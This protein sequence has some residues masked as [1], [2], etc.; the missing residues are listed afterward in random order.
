MSIDYR[1]EYNEYRERLW[2]RKKE[3][4]AQLSDVDLKQQDI[5]H[6]LEN[7]KCDAVTMVR[8]AK[9]LKT[10]RTERRLI[11]NEYVE[12]EPV[13]NRLTNAIKAKEKK[14]T[15]TY[16]TDIIV[17]CIGITLSN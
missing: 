13:C 2:A 11:K 7:E 9:R 10:L 16:K 8:L 3:L 5:L 17:E 14:D 15:Y 6:F 12:L 1:K 4:E